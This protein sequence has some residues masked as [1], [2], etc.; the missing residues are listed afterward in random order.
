MDTGDAQSVLERHLAM[1]QVDGV[2]VRTSWQTLEPTRRGYDWTAVNQ[3]DE[4]AA[5]QGK[6]WGLHVMASV[7]ATP[8]SWLAG[9]GMQTYTYRSPVGTTVTDPVPWDSVYLSEWRSFA[10]ALGAHLQSRGALDRLSYVS[11]AVPVAEMSLVG[12]ANGTMGTSGPAYQRTQYIGAWKSAIQSMD[13]A[14]PTVRKLLP[15]PVGIICRPDT[16]G[17]ALYTELFQ[18]AQSRS[19]PRFGLFATDLQGT[20]SSRLDGVSA[21]VDQAP[22]VLQFIGAASAPAGVPLSGTLL[23]AVCKG[24]QRYRGVAFE[25]YKADLASSDPAIQAAVAAIRAGEGCPSP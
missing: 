24:R 15:V 8:P 16:D 17:P 12:C 20:G 13:E 2:A 19:A 10:A 18:Y 14:L 6:K 7:F 25:T 22:V 9:Q 1:A 23:E 4:A 3:A 21:L 5:R 11:V